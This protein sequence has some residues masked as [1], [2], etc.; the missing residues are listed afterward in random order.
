MIGQD[1]QAYPLRHLARGFIGAAGAL[2]RPPLA[3]AGILFELAAAEAASRAGLAATLGLGEEP[4]GEVLN[5]FAARGWLTDDAREGPLR[6]SPAGH[7]AGRWLE[8]GA[9]GRVTDLLGTLSDVLRDRLREDARSL[10]DSLAGHVPAVPVIRRHRPGDLG[11]IAERH[12]DLYAREYGLDARFEAVVARICADFLAGHDPAT[13]AAFIA[14]RDGRRLGSSV[15]VREDRETARLR[16]VLLEPEARGHGLGKRLVATAEA[17]AR[18]AG[19]RRMVLWTLSPLSA[20]RAI[21]A[22][23]GWSIVS[24]TPDDSYGPTVESEVWAKSL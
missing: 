16:L 13:E 8:E 14:E 23:T 3:E 18:E 24:S 15:V 20:A 10:A 5:L 7:A 6:L 9:H 22:A 17:F 4:L 12:A 1:V 19:Y 11:W 2:G 21:Y